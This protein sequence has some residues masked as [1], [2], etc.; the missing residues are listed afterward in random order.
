MKNLGV[1][2]TVRR[3]IWSR[4]RGIDQP[5]RARIRLYS[6]LLRERIIF[7]GTPV[8]DTVA[9][10]VCAQLLFLESE[11]PTRTSTSTSTRPRR[12]HG[13]LRHLRH[14]EVHPRRRVDVLL[15]QAASAAAVLL[16][17]G[18]V[19]SAS[20]CPTP[21]SC[22][23]SPSAASRARRA[24]SSSRPRRSCACATCSPDARRGHGPAGREGV[25]GHRPR[26][27]HDRGRGGG[28]RVIDEV[29]TARAIPPPSRQWVSPEPAD[30]GTRAT[31]T[32]RANGQAREQ[33]WR[34]SV[35]RRPSE[36]QLLRK[37]A[38]AGEEVDR[39]P[40]VYIC[41]ECIDLCN[42]IIAEEL[43]DTTSSTSRTFQAA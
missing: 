10:L 26:L 6:R 43:T 32:N 30:S 24:T 9:N 18:P 4:R 31:R 15:R 28:L 36:V 16:A 8:D 41:D 13:A 37:V 14:H 17:S 22:C 40:G 5:R 34:S 27:H 2:R 20:R 1:T 7:L 12:D 3:T 23:T 21:A 19:A 33:T 35:R 29:I 42:D 38:E 11:E 39:R 25:E